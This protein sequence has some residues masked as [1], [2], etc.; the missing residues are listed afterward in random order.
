MNEQKRSRFSAYAAWL[1]RATRIVTVL[2]LCVF[3]V[4]IVTNHPHRAVLLLA[5]FS[6]F[7]ACVRAIFPG[8]PWFASRGRFFDCALW[9][10]VAV[11]CWWFAPWTATVGV[12]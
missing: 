4:L 5:G 8:R 6:L 3:L 12:G 11:A 10:L 2:W 7:Y 1:E 9:I